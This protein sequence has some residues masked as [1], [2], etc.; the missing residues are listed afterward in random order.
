M[1]AMEERVEQADLY[2]LGQ[3]RTLLHLYPYLGYSRPP[4]DPQMEA[5]VTRVLQE[6]GWEKATAKA[7]DIARARQWLQ[8]KDWRAEYV[9]RASYIVGLPQRDI[10]Q[11]LARMDVHVHH[12]TVHRWKID[13]LINLCAFLNGEME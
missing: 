7:A 13:G 12:V 3:L 11:Y 6:G 2:T 5:S 1:V 9:V 4:K 10:Q 8:E